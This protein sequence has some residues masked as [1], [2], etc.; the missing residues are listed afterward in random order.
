MLLKQAMSA[1]R[2]IFG[3]SQGRHGGRGRNPVFS[4]RGDCP[5]ASG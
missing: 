4:G 1:D 3:L 2:K 5:Y